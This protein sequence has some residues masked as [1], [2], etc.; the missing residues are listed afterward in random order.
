MAIYQS[1][2]DTLRETFKADR[3]VWSTHRAA[4]EAQLDADRNTIKRLAPNWWNQYGGVVT[5]VI[6]LAVGIGSSMGIIYL[7][8]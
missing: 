4:Y 3:S 1:A 6:G 8:K 2:Y 7:L 5:G